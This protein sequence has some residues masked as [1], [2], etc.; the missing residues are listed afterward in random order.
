MAVGAVQSTKRAL[1]T[2]LLAL[3]KLEGGGKETQEGRSEKEAG[4]REDSKEDRRGSARREEERWA[5]VKT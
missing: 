5:G 4:S 2:S 1:V 3:A